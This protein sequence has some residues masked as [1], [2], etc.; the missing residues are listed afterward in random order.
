MTSDQEVTLWLPAP[1]DASVQA[2]SE[3]YVFGEWRFSTKMIHLDDAEAEHLLL[4]EA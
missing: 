1:K 2:G 3:D 4:L